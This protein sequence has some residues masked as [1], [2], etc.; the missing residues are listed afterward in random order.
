[1][2]AGT[3]MHVDVGTNPDVGA[4]PDVGTNAD[5]V[6]AALADPTRRQLLEALGQRPAASATTLAALVPV[7]RQA[8]AKHLAV[9]R[10]SRLVT[11]HR[12]GKEVLFSVHP[13]Q[14]AATASW[15]TRL[16]E[17]WQQ[18]LELLKRRAELG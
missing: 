8:V 14:L 11:S 9:L 2:N 16:S 18:R 4:N 5:R 15:M 12:A 1:M 6:F 13:E 7:S 17:T 10:E 3:G